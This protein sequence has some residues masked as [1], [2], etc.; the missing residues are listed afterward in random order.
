MAL[1]GTIRKNGWILIVAMA[2]ALGGFILMD[3]VQNSS[4][5]S[6]ADINTLGKVNGQA[7]KRSD[8][9]NYNALIYTN[10][11]NSYQSR[12]Q[13][14]E[15]FVENAIIKQEAEVLGLGVDRE[16]LRDLQFGD[17]LSP[18]IMQRYKT[19]D[20]QPD[21]NYLNSI[22]NAIDNRREME[23]RF[24][25]SW[26]EQEKE[27]IKARLEDKIMA[28]VTKGLYAP[29]WQAEMVY[30]ENSQ[31][32]DFCY[33]RIPYDKVKE[34]EAPVTDADYKAFLKENPHLYDQP[35]ETRVINYVVFDAIPTPADS[36]TARD[37][38]A[39][40]VDGLRTS[41]NDSAFV[42]TNNGTYT[43]AYRLKNE[44][45]AIMTDTLMK[46]PYGTVI[47]P[48]LDGNT[49]SI[50]KILD[51][52]QVPDSVR[53][54]H[55]AMQ[56]TPANESRLD[57]LLDLLNTGKARF[58]SLAVRFSLDTKSAPAGGDLGW[59]GR[60]PAAEGN[61][62]ANL[63]FYKA[64]Q[65]KYYK[66]KNSQIVQLVELTGKKFEKNETGV[67]AVFLSQRVEPSKNTQQTVKDRAVALVQQAKTLEAF[68]TQATQQS[69]PVQTSSPLKEADFSIGALGM[70]EDTRDIVRWAFDQK[71]KLNS[72][73]QEVFVF[74]DDAGGYFDS[75]YV[76]AALKT[77]VPKGP[78]DVATLKANLEADQKVKNLKKAEV[79]ISK[80]LTSADNLAAIAKT[81]EVE[82]DTARGATMLQAG[83]EPR[84]IG[85][86]FSMEKNAVSPPIAGNSAVWV[87]SPIMD[88]PELQLPADLTLYRRQ[89]SSSAMSTIRVGLMNSLIKAAELQDFR[90]RFY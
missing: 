80:T 55:I 60:P 62:F 18:V 88:K 47:G 11:D 34:E 45:P 19:A 17:N 42:L 61:E 43:P 64:E 37:A 25:L 82:V 7:I 5:Y 48:Y 89:A 73:S 6:A 75:K 74:R 46:L 12:Q 40:L 77:I 16:E 27:I 39:K 71:T 14:W 32:L 22:K 76:V 87:V 53:V 68:T 23:P 49:W 3:I 50:A 81:W 29:K 33:V 4:N 66:L 90:S 72:V 20:N 28:M 57:S 1:I 63:V 31:R 54:S 83:S 15:F 52:K 44:L 70:G 9:E 69:L 79:I 59:I 85:T 35:E 38:V 2:L 36:A 56:P 78:A 51:R 67:K 21:Y 84:V 41:A 30:R 26:A 10:Q 86:A 58:D 65:G 8:F 13:S 24:I